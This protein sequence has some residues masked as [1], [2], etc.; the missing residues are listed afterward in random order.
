[1]P[2]F[3]QRVD[4][5][6]EE[7]GFVL[8]SVLLLAVLFFGLMNLVLRESMDASHSA[9]RF[10]ARIVSEVLAENAAELA[11]REMVLTS[12]A[13]RS[14]ENA[15]GL[16]E[17]SFTRKPGDAFVIT[18]VAETKGILRARTSV[19]IEGRIEGTTIIIEK[20]VHSTETMGRPEK[21]PEKKP[22]KKS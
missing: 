8:V 6:A 14:A 9:Q 3:N 16:M 17:G 21:K 10:R 7:R 19:L 15:D 20:T 22:D 12:G 2:A 18:G 1:M 11:A 4:Q 5:R 13:E